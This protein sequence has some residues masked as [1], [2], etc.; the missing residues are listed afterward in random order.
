MKGANELGLFDMS[1]N[2]GEWCHDWNAGL[3]A[4]MLA[5]YEGPGTGTVKVKK[6]SNFWTQ[7]ATKLS[8]RST[9]S[10]DYPY[11]RGEYDG[12]RIVRSKN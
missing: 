10:P 4:G 9:G 11:Y 6:G 8:A 12:L 3:P 5:D 2:V 7:N 1:G